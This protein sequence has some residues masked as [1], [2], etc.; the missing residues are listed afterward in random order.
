LQ[1]LGAYSRF[2]W[3]HP[4]P[5][6]FYFAAPL[7]ELLSEHGPALNLF[8]LISNL[9]CILSS[10]LIIRRLLGDFAGLVAAVLFTVYT[11]AA[12]PYV[13]TN[14]WNP[15]YPILP[16]ALTLLLIVAFAAGWKTLPPV[17][18]L[19]SL[20]IQTHVGF[21]PA[22]LAAIFYGIAARLARSND[23]PAPTRREVLV[24]A[25]VAGLCWLL[26]MWE[27][28]LPG[29][30]NINLLLSFFVPKHWSEHSFASAIT[31]VLTQ[32]SSLPVAVLRVARASNEPTALVKIWIGALLVCALIASQ[33][34]L[35]P[36][37]AAV[38]HLARLSLL[39]CVIAVVAVRAI[40][41]QLEPYLLVWISVISVSSMICV[42]LWGYGA[43][44]ARL[45]GP[46][47]HRPTIL[48]ACAVAAALSVT[49]LT[50]TG[51]I[52]RGPAFQR[53]DALTAALADRVEAFLN[54][55]SNRRVALRVAAD[56]VWPQAAGVALRLTKRNDAVLVDQK[57]MSIF[58]DRRLVS[59]GHEI[60]LIF[61]DRP[62]SAQP[63]H[64]TDVL[65]A[66]DD[67]VFVYGV[68][69]SDTLPGD[70]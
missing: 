13:M 4:G 14:E 51:P 58:G 25:A 38:Q 44:C 17:F 52:A 57:W 35:S 24:A 2:G 7:Y 10:V 41:G 56:S 63:A 65:V 45:A 8:A 36:R 18:L 12:V 43:F 67:N 60:T 42:S 5:L 26:P 16:F 47:L 1:F 32:M 6:F 21:A 55:G 23:C 37:R 27:I 48:A 49:L 64:S 29:R 46:R 50:L 20:V 59:N 70:R 34:H 61:T 9:L 68:P 3:S 11:L 22:I 62:L 30:S 53:G 66:G 28:A 69:P 31:V 54:A 19:S 33:M 39:Q 15:I 40:R